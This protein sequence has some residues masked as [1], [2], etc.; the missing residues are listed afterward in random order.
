VGVL[1]AAVLAFGSGCA[2]SDWIDRTLVTVDVTGVWTGWYTSTWGPVD[3]RLELQQQGPNV[4]GYFQ[5]LGRSGGSGFNVS[6]PLEGTVAGDVFRFKVTRGSISG[7]LMVSG[8]E[9]KGPA[10]TPTQSAVFLQRV[11]SSARPGPR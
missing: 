8:D 5:T 2:R 10:T 1:I 11:D 9:M 3:V 4:I 7:E 6:G